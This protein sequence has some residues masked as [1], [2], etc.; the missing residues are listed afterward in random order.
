MA[1]GGTRHAGAC[2][3]DKHTLIR[4]AKP[5]C[6]WGYSVPPVPEWTTHFD[7]AREAFRQHCIN[8]HGLDKD[9]TNFC[10]HLDVLKWTLEL[11]RY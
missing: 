7:R 8:R 4:C 6:V 10:I 1:R 11:L 5:D 2:F 3:M 9:D